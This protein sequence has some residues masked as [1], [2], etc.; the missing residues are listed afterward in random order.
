MKKQFY[1]WLLF[2]CSTLIYGQVGINTTDPKTT[3][4]VNGLDNA[5]DIAGLQAPRLS[6]AELALKGNTR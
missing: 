5:S 6:L 1:F 2:F 3:L 4:D